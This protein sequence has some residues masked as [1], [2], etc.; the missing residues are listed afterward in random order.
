[1]TEPDNAGSNPTHAV[2][3]RVR[4]GDDYVIDGHK[5]FTTGADGAAFAIVMASPT[6]TPPEHAA[7]QHVARADRHARLRLVRNIPIMG[8]AGWRLGQP[9][10]DRATRVPRA[11]GRDR[12]GPEGGGFAIAQERLGPGRIHHCMRWI[13]ICERAFDLM[14]RRA[15]ARE[16]APVCRWVAADRA[17]LDRRVAG[18][19]STPRG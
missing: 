14:C 16:L 5:W 10:R 17:G 9:R 4:D 12:L 13:G 19:R 1:M 8:D 18:P 7:R 2:D 15:A 6:P 3:R 11:R